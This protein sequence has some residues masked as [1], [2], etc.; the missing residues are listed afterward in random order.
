LR[1]LGFER[2]ELFES[3][4]ACHR[5]TPERE[6][7]FFNTMAQ[8]KRL[9]REYERLAKLYLR[10]IIEGKLDYRKTFFNRFFKLMQRLYYNHEVAGGCP[11]AKGQIAVSSNGDVYPCTSFL[12]ISKFKLGNV[13]TGLSKKRYNEFSQSINRRF[14]NCRK[15]S[16][17]SICRTTG[18]CLNMNYYFNKDEALPYQKSCNLFREKLKLAIASLAILKE[19]IPRRIEKLFGYDPVGKRGNELY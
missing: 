2:I 1:D 12:G 3:E 16:V 18:S 19:R 4:D 14:D 5:I 17:F 10:E 13:T 7:V 8:Y 15:C 9:H 11:A 6:S